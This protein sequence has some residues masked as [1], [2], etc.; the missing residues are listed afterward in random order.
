MFGRLEGT[1]EGGIL[2]AAWIAVSLGVGVTWHVKPVRCLRSSLGADYLKSNQDL[3][4]IHRDD[5]AGGCGGWKSLGSAGGEEGMEEAQQYSI[6][7]E[8]LNHMGDFLNHIG[9]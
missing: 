9:T 5:D 2:G 1:G 4:T 7:D 6:E 3:I 8:F